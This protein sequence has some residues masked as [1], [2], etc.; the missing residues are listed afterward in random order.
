MIATCASAP[1]HVS[2]SI[3]AMSATVM[4]GASGVSVVAMP[5]TACATTATATILRPW[6]QAAP[7]TLPT[8]WTPNANAARANADGSVKPSQ[9]ANAPGSPARRYPRPIPTCDDAGPGRNWH[10]ATRSA[11]ASSPSLRRRS[12][13][14]LRK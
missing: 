1:V 10:S 9:A 12:T 4:R 5:H 6:S 8:A 11:Y 2:A 14:S 13:H 7:P 3:A